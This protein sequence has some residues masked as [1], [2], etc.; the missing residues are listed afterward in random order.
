MNL[1]D[2][3]D[4]F[5]QLGSRLQNIEDQLGLS[6]EDGLSADGDGRSRQS[7]VVQRHHLHP[8]A[9][10]LHVPRRG[11]G[12][13]QPLR[14]ELAFVK[15]PRHGVLSGCARRCADDLRPP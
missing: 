11:H 12:L 10:R 5:V 14:V 6:D 7:S 15:H 9:I 4:R 2:L 8:V 3:L 1:N 13:A